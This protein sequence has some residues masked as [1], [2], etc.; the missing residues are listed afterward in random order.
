MALCRQHKAQPSEVC[1]KFCVL[2]LL[3]M[4]WGLFCFVFRWGFILC[5]VLSLPLLIQIKNALL[6]CVCANGS[7]IP[8]SLL[9]S[10]C[11]EALAEQRPRTIFPSLK[12][13]THP[14]FSVGC[15]SGPKKYH[16]WYFRCRLQALSQELKSYIVFQMSS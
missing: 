10:F 16:L 5:L 15:V 11:L 7:R 9:P 2:K 4:N 6:V 12:L 1:L 8:F 3:T 13:V 14:Q